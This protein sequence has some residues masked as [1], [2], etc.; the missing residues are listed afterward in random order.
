MHYNSL[1]LKD[2]VLYIQNFVKNSRCAGELFGYYL[3]KFYRFWICFCEN[4]EQ[5]LWGHCIKKGKRESREWPVRLISAAGNFLKF[6]M[7][8]RSQSVW[9]WAEL[10]FFYERKI[11]F[12]K[13]LGSLRL[14]LV[15]LIRGKPVDAAYETYADFDWEVVI[16]QKAKNRNKWIL[17]WLSTCESLGTNRTPDIYCL[18]QQFCWVNRIFNF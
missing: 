4:G 18:F 15:Q 10:A 17:F 8:N 13:W 3:F 7:Q 5:K 11:M 12:Y 14:W 16:G 6:L 9:G 2:L 1:I